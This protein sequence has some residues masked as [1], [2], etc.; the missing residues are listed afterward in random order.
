[1]SLALL[2]G[3]GAMSAGGWP[4]FFTLLFNLLDSTLKREG[5]P[6]ELLSVRLCM[7]VIYIDRSV[8]FH[9]LDCV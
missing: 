7:F 1:M 4:L 8:Y 5:L 3:F 6:D 9:I 2:R